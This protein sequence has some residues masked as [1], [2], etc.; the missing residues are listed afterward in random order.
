M[1]IELSSRYFG[2]ARTDISD[3]STITL[4]DSSSL[5]VNRRDSL[6]SLNETERGCHV[7]LDLLAELNVDSVK[8]SMPNDS[9][10]V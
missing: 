7:S 10:D 8:L 5:N 9:H 2:N 3:I 4:Q 1:S 6:N